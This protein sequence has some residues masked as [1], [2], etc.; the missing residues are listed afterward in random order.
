[1]K[2]FIPVLVLLVGCS[3]T[4]PFVEVGVGHNFNK[5][6]DYL[7][8]QTGSWIQRDFDCT[9]FHGSVGVELENDWEFKYIHR[10]CI[11]PGLYTEVPTDEL[12]ISKRIYF[13]E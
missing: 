12:V 8:Y 4:K 3:N 5:G 13:N 7:V 2:K 11:D 9:T 10:S 6:P 1:M